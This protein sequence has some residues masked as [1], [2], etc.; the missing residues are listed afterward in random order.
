MLNLKTLAKTMACV[1]G[2]STC[3][4]AWA[5]DFYLEEIVVTAQKR[6]QSAQAL[7]VAITAVSGEALREQ[8]IHN[9]NDLER[10]IP[11]FTIK[12]SGGLVVPIVRGVGLQNFRINDSPTASFYID[13]VYQTSVAS[14][15]F[16]MYDL[17]RVEVL[18][19]PQGG[20][21]G[22][23]SIAAAIQVI[24]AKPKVGEAA[25]GDLVLGY[26]SYGSKETEFGA[27]FPLSDKA[28]MRIAGRWEN[29]DDGPSRGVQS[30]S[31]FGAVDRSALRVQMSYQANEDLEFLFKLHGGQDD[32]E[33]PMLRTVGLYTDIGD[34]TA[35]GFSTLS[36]GMLGGLLAP[37]TPGT[38]LCASIL[39]GR[40]SDPESCATVT[41]V[42]P[43]NLGLG[44]STGSSRFEAVDPSL[45]SRVENE[46]LGA[47]AIANLDLGDYRL[48]SVS[49]FDSLDYRRLIDFDGTS[50]E[51]QDT[52]YSSKIDFWAQE[53]RLAY[54]G[55]ETVDWLLGIN[56]AED[57]LD[58]Y[59]VLSGAEG[60]LPILFG[61]A[62]FSP[63]VYKQNTQ[64]LAV[65]GHGEW[66]LTDGW[67]A[68]GEL[69]YTDAD[70]SFEG[71]QKFG[72]ADGSTVPFFL[73]DE[74]TSF[75]SFSG[76]LALEWTPKDEMLIY[77]SVSEG[78]KTG[79]YFGGFITSL[80]QFDSFDEE[81]IL[82]YEMGIKSDWLNNHLRV[83]ASAFYYDRSDVQQSASNPSGGT[84]RVARLT[85][86]GDVET[87]GAELDLIWLPT[88]SLQFNVSLGYTDAEIV[89]SDFVSV[90]AVPFLDSGSLEG[91]NVPN[92]SKFSGNFSGR[93]E[94]ALSDSILASVQL[95]Y[96]YRTKRDLTPILNPETEKALF[97]EPAYGLVNLRVGLASTSDQWRISAFVENLADEEYRVEAGS[98]GLLG[99]VE[100]YGEPRVWGLNMSYSWD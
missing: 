45:K 35:F 3:F 42:T 7:G 41:G 26:G 80:G 51:S 74:S 85:N 71:E 60:V 21:Y 48:T 43:T 70:K 30:R 56:Y 93:Y 46:W 15:A 82:A 97:Q 62:T 12:N 6:T 83:N 57:Q 84:A 24:S 10:I 78:F 54:T 55:S 61:G 86:I 52:D 36:M 89:D 23:N 75:E 40:G 64:A 20:I 95:E 4:S 32:S 14:A 73:A 50:I 65:F 16:S 98:D 81:T 92:Y 53:V 29:S 28:A 11:N 59:S 76:K 25:S 22:R 91:L 96:S 63:Q 19:G 79:G 77:A 47:S 100:R 9:G 8:G 66:D 58:E 49:S 90:S 17:E 94:K 13:E 44:A 37:G 68:I 31:N 1:V 34:A 99:L 69:R 18:K 5:D 27:S 88:A 33:L 2:G 38:G 39:A 72:F 67:R 87:T